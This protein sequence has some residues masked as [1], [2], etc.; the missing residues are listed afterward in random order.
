MYR[1]HLPEGRLVEPKL[2]ALAAYLGTAGVAAYDD[3]YLHKG[4]LL[5]WYFFKDTNT[6]TRSVEN[7]LRREYEGIEEGLTP[8]L[9]WNGDPELYHMTRRSKEL[10]ILKLAALDNE[11][12]FQT[13]WRRRTV[14][15]DST[16]VIALRDGS[17][18]IEVRSAHSKVAALY[19]AV[20]SA[21]K[22]KLESGIECDLRDVAKRTALKD[23]LDARCFFA[24]H[25]HDDTEVSRTTVEAQPE[26][27][28]ES[29]TRLNDIERGAGV[30][31]FSRSYDFEYEHPDGYKE[32]CKYRVRLS[33]GQVRVEKDMSEP[34]I[35]V[36]Q[37]HVV[38]L[39]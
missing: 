11:R 10:L 15:Y 6:T 24:Q 3:L 35:R 18:T 32:L 12:V 28:L 37:Q 38:S 39:F 5:S 16:Y 14:R 34:A 29:G 9:E 13:N 19:R 23:A 31:G 1:K 17:F 22:L 7:R 21:I 26:Y 27:D 33:N 36:L 2:E 25:R 4:G 8:D 30:T 20:S